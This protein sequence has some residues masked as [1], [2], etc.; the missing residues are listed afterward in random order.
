MPW[1]PGES[2]NPKGRPRNEHTFARM[3]R[4]D[5]N[6][7]YTRLKKYA[8]QKDDPKLAAQVLMFFI[9]YSDGKPEST[10]NLRHDENPE[11]MSDAELEALIRGADG[12]ADSGVD[13]AAPASD[14]NKLH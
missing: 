1:K 6:E 14:P 5:R 8:R 10:V 3:C 2:G 13:A 7:W 4:E 12:P 9:G 11:R